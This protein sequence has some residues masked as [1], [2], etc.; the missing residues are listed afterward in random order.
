M[1]ENIVTLRACVPDTEVE[2]EHSA[3][4]QT[5]DYILEMVQQL[6]KLARDPGG[7]APRNHAR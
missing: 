5:C 7:N 3:A 2:A 4:D 1:K 6:A